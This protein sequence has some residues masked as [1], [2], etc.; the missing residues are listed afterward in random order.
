MSI[1]TDLIPLV[2]LKAQYATLRS[3]MLAALA[4]TLERGDYILGQDVQMFENEFAAY[5]QVP[6]AVGCASGTDALQLAFR[7]LDIGPGDE[8]IVPAM[9]FMATALGVMLVG[10]TPVFV[11]VDSQTGLLDPSLLESSI[12]S[13]TKA[14]CPVHLYGQCAPM[15]SILEIAKKFGLKV[16]EDAAQAHGTFYQGRQHAGTMGDVGCF[17]FY[18]G[19]NLGAYG[20]GGAVV[21][22]DEKLATRLRSLRNLG[23]LQKY[24]HEELGLNS[25][26]DT[27][28]ATVLRLKLPHLNDWNQARRRHAR[29]YDLALKD[30]PGVT[31]TSYDI[32]GNYHLYVIRLVNRDVALRRLN[33]AGIG[34]GIHYPFALH[35][36]QACRH[37]T[38]RSFPMA[39]QWAATGLSLPMYPELPESAIERAAHLLASL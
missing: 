37:L 28:Q 12:T 35:Q 38:D 9:T 27:L 1:N 4:T 19:K 24:H 5:C 8:V 31:L 33:D 22:H 26:L 20:D 25:R 18:P 16:V 7:A 13:R 15:T 6:Y 21:T 14:I 34:A 11:D 39:E 30:I 10:A 32:T 2:N 29:L 36:L 23:S 17:S 3:S